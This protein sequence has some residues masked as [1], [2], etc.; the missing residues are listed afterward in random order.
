MVGENL[1]TAKKLSDQ[2]T[3]FLSDKVNPY[4]PS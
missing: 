2:S 3:N 1:V 4:S